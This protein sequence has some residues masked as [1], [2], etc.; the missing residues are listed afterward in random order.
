MDLHEMSTLLDAPS[1]AVLTTYRRNGTAVSSPVWFRY[2]EDG[3]QIVIAHDD[4]K[5][6]H[7]DKHPQCSLVVFEAVP[8][9]RGVRVEGTPSIDEAGVNEARREIAS[10]YLGRD[11]GE[12]F[13]A[14]RGPGV[15]LHLPALHAH[16]WD[17][18][19]ILPA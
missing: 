6:R 5:L 12:R 13:T 18:T 9:F 15:L 8:P 11:A 10:K 4:V 17:L 14:E 19:T 7:L 1:P 16:A 3:F 2:I